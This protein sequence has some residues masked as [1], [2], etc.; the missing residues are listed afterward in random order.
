MPSKD[1]QNQNS[2]DSNKSA[3]ERD[4]NDLPRLPGRRSV[5]EVLAVEIDFDVGSH[6][7]GA[8]PEAS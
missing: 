2:K 4:A 8:I 6:V 7:F 3:D 1:T 5:R